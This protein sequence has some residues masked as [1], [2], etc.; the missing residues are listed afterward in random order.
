MVDTVNK[1]YFVLTKQKE[2]QEREK[3][4]KRNILIKIIAGKPFINTSVK[5]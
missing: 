2:E 3:K 5:K 1:E 4:E